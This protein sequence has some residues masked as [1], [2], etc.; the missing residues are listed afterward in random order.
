VYL[1]KL[2][3]AAMPKRSSGHRKQ[4]AL[5]AHGSLNPHPETVT[6]TLFQNS[7]FFDPT[8]LVQV[9]YEMLRRVDADI[10]PISRA[11]QEF[12]FSR[13]SFYQAQAA[14][15]QSG[16]SGL[17]PQKRG[18]R[19]AHKLTV[20]IMEFIQQARL[21]EPSLRWQELADRVK[22]RFDVSVH[23]RS[24]ERGVARGQKNGADRR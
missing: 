18:P 9:K 16:L 22:E 6:S 21:A 10:Q 2:L 4:Q 20:P 5:R 11:T 13:L 3:E 15:Q 14:F 12:G 7:D 8:D 17:I 24:I 19:Q 23:P 1:Q